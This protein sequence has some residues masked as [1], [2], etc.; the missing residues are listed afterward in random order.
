LDNASG[1]VVAYVG[2]SGEFSQA[3]QVDAAWALRQAGSTLKPFLY[4]MALEQK[5]LTAASLLDDSAL[6]IRTA[7]AQYIPRNYSEDYKGWVSVR[8]ALASSLN[9]PAVRTLSMLDVNDFAITLRKVGLTSV[10]HDG[11]YYGPSLA[12]G[13]ADI[14][15]VDLANAYRTIANQGQYSE[16]TF[17]KDLKDLK[18]LKAPPSTQVMLPSVAYIVS[19]ML[20]DNEARATSFGLDSALRLPFRASVK[21]G[22]S[23][24]MRDNWCVGFTDRYTVAV[25][26]G[27]ASGAPMR[28]VSGVSGA[29]PIWNSVMRYVHQS[30][31]SVGAGA[32]TVQPAGVRWQKAKFFGV[33]EPERMELFLA[34]T[35]LSEVTLGAKFSRAANHIIHPIHGAVYAID[36]D[37]PRSKQLIRFSHSGTTAQSASYRWRLDN[38]WLANASHPTQHHWSLVPGSHRLELVSATGALIEAVRFEVRHQYHAATAQ[39]QIKPGY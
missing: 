29:A 37:I 1:E 17:L 2:S 20:A 38:K 15:L 32:S 10:I 25:W 3:S 27:N 11:G 36:P 34:G 14:R 23:K 5:R 6:A 33:S 9:I 13:S 19:D 28:G 39:K 16:L 35:E 21:T 8:K 26:V 24:D 22:T 4:G 31:S 12:L 18:D 30:A 7:D